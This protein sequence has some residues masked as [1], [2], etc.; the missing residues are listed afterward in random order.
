MRQRR[1]QVPLENVARDQLRIAGADRVDEILVM[2]VLG[3]RQT[4]R[5]GVRVRRVRS[6]S[7]LVLGTEIGLPSLYGFVDRQPPLGAVE[8]VADA[9]A[10]FVVRETA[11][12]A[13]LEQKTISVN[14][15]TRMKT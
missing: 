14:K 9:H 15:E 4:G 11:E 7:L 1:G 12:R 5:L 13:E 3:R 8:Q 6:R 10:G 2:R